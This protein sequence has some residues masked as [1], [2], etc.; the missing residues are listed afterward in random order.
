SASVPHHS[1]Y[2]GGILDCESCSTRLSWKSLEIT[3]A[4][5]VFVYS[6]I[7]R[8]SG[9]TLMWLK[10]PRSRSWSNTSV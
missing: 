4:L 9:D 3:C 8:P 5:P 10:G 6:A 7:S 2:L 1:T